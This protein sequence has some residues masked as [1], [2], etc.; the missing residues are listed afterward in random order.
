V[1]ALLSM[2]CGVSA[3]GCAERVEPRTAP[4]AVAR[5]TYTHLLL[6]L[7]LIALSSSVW[8]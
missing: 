8:K 5:A 3:D 7:L 4:K 6:T 1:H 2:R